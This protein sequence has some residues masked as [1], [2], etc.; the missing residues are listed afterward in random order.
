MEN[1]IYFPAGAHESRITKI[2]R[3]LNNPFEADIECTYAVDYGRISQ[4]ENNIVD[5][6]AAYKE[7]L[8][9]EVLAVLK[10]WDSIDP[11]EYNVLFRRPDYQSDSEFDQQAGK[12]DL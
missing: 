11:T 8:N 12:G 6:Q 10:S 1:E 4:I 2:S 5:I 9:K 3:K 7:Q